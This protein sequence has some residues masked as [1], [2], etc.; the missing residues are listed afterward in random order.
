MQLY[1]IPSQLTGKARSVVNNAGRALVKKKVLM[2]GS[3]EIDTINNSDIYDTY[4]DLYLS[5]KLGEKKLLQGIQLANGLKA[6]V[7]AK[8]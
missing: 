8:K 5:K 4:R 3:K 7:G 2:V 1:R 6:R